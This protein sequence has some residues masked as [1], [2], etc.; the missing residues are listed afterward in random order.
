MAIVHTFVNPNADD[1]TAA[2]EQETL[3]SHWNAAH[4]L[5]QDNTWTG[6][7]TY[8]P[9]PSTADAIKQGFLI[10]QS[11]SGSAA[12]PWPP[13]G[14]EP[15]NSII[16]SDTSQANLA[17]LMIYGVVSTTGWTGVKSGVNSTVLQLGTPAGGTLN[18]LVAGSFTA[19]SA[20]VAGVGSEQTV[21]ALN[22]TAILS[23][24]ATGYAGCVGAEFD[25]AISTTASAD[26]RVGV[27]VISSTTA[28]DNGIQGT[29][30]SALIVGTN[31]SAAKWQN[32]LYFFS[33]AIDTTGSLISAQG[34]AGTIATGIDLSN[35]TITG[36]AL[37]MPAT[38]SLSWDNDDIRILHSAN[39]L[40]F[41]G[42]A[43]GYAFDASVL[44]TVDGVPGI[45]TA[46]LGF[47]G[48]HL[49][50][51]A[52]INWD[53]GDVTIAHSAN[54]LAFTGATSGYSFDTY[55][56]TGTIA[57]GSLP[58]AAA[59]NKGARYMVSDSNATMTAGIGAVVAAGGANIVPVYSDGTNWRIG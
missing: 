25:I 37:K 18:Q 36:S 59:G 7:N 42:A 12:F 27:M 8:N 57:V 19:R 56:K 24:G 39:L 55:V 28:T 31:A 38:C 48:V 11:I 4:D 1:P 23:A 17:G 16:F 5:S 51:A 3:P 9:T 33:D 2:A 15:L 44:P 45:G 34:S 58:G 49:S 47:S 21:F 14:I 50:A 53:S 35:F 13:Y 41:L 29:T 30:D 10:N 32:G 46:G 40:L 54:A 52:M 6:M 20:V 22:P 43:N 26:V